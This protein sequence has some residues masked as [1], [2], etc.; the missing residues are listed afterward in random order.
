MD[1]CESYTYAR[2]LRFLE[3]YY[4]YDNE[5]IHYADVMLSMNQ[6][7][8]IDELIAVREQLK[9]KVEKILYYNVGKLPKDIINEIS[10]SSSST[11]YPSSTTIKENLRADINSCYDENVFRLFKERNTITANLCG[12]CFINLSLCWRGS[13]YK[14]LIINEAKAKA[15][16]DVE[17]L[18]ES[19][20][21]RNKDFVEHWNIFK[22]FEKGMNG[23]NSAKK[24]VEDDFEY[25]QQFNWRLLPGQ[26]SLYSEIDREEQKKRA[27]QAKILIEQREEELR[28]R[29]KHAKFLK[30]QRE[31]KERQKKLEEENKRNKDVAIKIV[32]IIIGSLIIIGIMIWIFSWGKEV[33]NIFFFF[34]LWLAIMKTILSKL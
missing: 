5:D 10:K 14:E 23:Y 26:K 17:E 32:S 4:P 15:N 31:E 2:T 20:A 34:L 9:E 25:L 3:A 13:K 12:E 7:K 8:T 19:I 24:V 18:L 16:L 6:C 11:Y 28:K 33:G 27:E 30:E 22:G 1:K 21:K 29:E